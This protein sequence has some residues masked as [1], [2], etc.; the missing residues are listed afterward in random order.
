MHQH[1]RGKR[2]A[3]GAEG[4]G[5][6]RLDGW[7]GGV[8]GR[9]LF[10]RAPQDL[11]THGNSAVPWPGH[12]PQ[13]AC[14]DGR[15]Y[16]IFSVRVVVEVSLKDLRRRQREQRTAEGS[17]AITA[18]GNDPTTSGHCGSPCF[19]ANGK[20]RTTATNTHTHRHTH[21]DTHTHTHTQKVY[22][23]NIVIQ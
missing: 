21:T 10:L 1:S 20:P 2:G 19:P 17:W 13:E 18:D 9:S 14:V 22:I 12:D 3:G 5:G 7:A 23:W 11:C 15:V 16:H 8:G 6:K 4:W